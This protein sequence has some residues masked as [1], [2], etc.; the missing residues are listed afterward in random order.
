MRR[1]TLRVAGSPA[2]ALDLLPNSSRVSRTRIRASTSRCSH[3]ASTVVDKVASGQ[4]DVGLIAEPVPHPAVRTERLAE[5]AMCCIVPRG[6]G[7][8]ASAWCG[9]PI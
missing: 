7:S 9:R 6:T 2:V 8:R 3:S 4:C 1:G 5:G